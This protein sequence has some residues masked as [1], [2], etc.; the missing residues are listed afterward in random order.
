MTFDIS[1]ATGANGVELDTEVQLVK[2]AVI[3]GDHVTLYSPVA[4]ML[5][6]AAYVGHG[7]EE[8]RLAFLRQIAP[9]L[10]QPELAAGLEVWEY[11][12]RKR[13][14]TR[15]EL[16]ALTRARRVLLEAWGPLTEKV[17]EI[18]ISAGADR[19]IGA[20]EAGILTLHP[21]A[22]NEDDDFF[23]A[24]I[25]RLADVF[26]DAS[27]YPMFDETISG[28]VRAAVRERELAP[29]PSATSR[30]R[31]VSAA[32]DFLGRLPTFPHATVDEVL[33]I[34]D[35]LRGPLTNFRSAMVAVSRDVEAA[36]YDEDFSG[37][38]HDLWVETVA[39]AID[40]IRQLVAENRYLHQLCGVA[41]RDAARLLAAGAVGA[42]VGVGVTAVADLPQLIAGGSAA[43]GALLSPLWA[44]KVGAARIHQH[45]FY[46]LHATEAH[47]AKLAS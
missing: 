22:E 2:P 4:A 11:L 24:F 5:A 43:A 35:E 23:D 36:A 18:L 26:G 31:Q 15:Q 10:G 3:Y 16:Q 27:G 20:M 12:R 25:A 28:L 13:R 8:V 19:L 45:R 14:R 33:D 7:D 40:E 29:T 17:D 30:G 6:S 34:R 46:L 47:L 38:V 1:I 39:P 41:G 21:L 9:T 32:A 37:Q 42:L 44:K